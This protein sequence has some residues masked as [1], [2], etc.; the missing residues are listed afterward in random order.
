M[1]NVR[2]ATYNTVQPPQIQQNFFNTN[3]DYQELNYEMPTQQEFEDSDLEDDEIIIET[4]ETKKSKKIKKAKE[5]MKTYKVTNFSDKGQFVKRMTEAYTKSLKERGISTK[6]VPMLVAQDALESG[7]GQH[8]SGKNNFGGIKGKGTV[9]L[10]KEQVNGRLVSTNQ[11]FRDFSSLKEYTDY[12][13]SLLNNNRYHAFDGGDF[14]TNV[15][16]GGY[17][18]SPSYLSALQ[19]QYQKVLKYYV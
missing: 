5:K 18:T 14:F 3:S 1:E 15:V 8:Q 9:K 11:E 4:E 10:T 16:K 6:Y 17:A 7:W 2:W 12:K 19:Q 13:V